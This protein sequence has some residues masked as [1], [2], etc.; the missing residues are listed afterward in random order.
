MLALLAYA[1]KNYPS[2]FGS[3]CVQIRPHASSFLGGISGGT[4]VSDYVHS[5][6]K[7][8]DRPKWRIPPS[9]PLAVRGRS[10]RYGKACNCIKLSGMLT[11]AVS[12]RLTCEGVA[13]TIRAI[14]CIPDDP[15][16]RCSKDL[17]EDGRLA[18]S[19]RS[20][21]KSRPEAD[22]RARFIRNSRVARAIPTS[23][24]FRR[25]RP[26]PSRK[27]RRPLFLRE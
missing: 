5:D 25:P 15:E 16:C 17:D 7:Q 2:I 8:L 4:V 23:P 27:L 19:N 10:V 21:A 1:E 9:P 26:H 3:E 13:A 22:R 18:P 11:V 6:K 24:R 14:D 12:S 20:F